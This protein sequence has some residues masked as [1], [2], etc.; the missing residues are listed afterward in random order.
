MGKF[1]TLAKNTAASP[2]IKNYEGAKAYKPSARLDLYLA[3]ATT[4]LDNSFYESKDVR[5]ERIKEL[6]KQ[7]GPVFTVQL[8]AYCRD[9]L[10]MR[11][12]SVALL[13]E[14]AMLKDANAWKRAEKTLR[15]YVPRIL[16]RADELAEFISY[17]KLYNGSVK[18]IPKPIE[19]GMSDALNR[20]SEYQL[21]KYRGDS[22]AV[23][24][25]DV[26]RII[27]PK[28]NTSEKAAL[29]KRALENELATPETWEVEI[30]TKGSTDE[31]WNEI[32]PKMGIMALLRNLRNFE[33]KGAEKALQHAISVLTNK[34][35][36]VNSKQL[37]FRWFS[38][39][40]QVTRT[41]TQNA[42]CDAMD[43]SVENV[44]GIS[45]V[46]A[47]FC[48][49]SGSMAAPVSGKSKVSRNDAA[50]ILS[51][52]AFKKGN[53][54]VLAGVFGDYFQT[55]KLNQRDT[56]LTNAQKLKATQVGCSTNGYLSIQ[57]LRENGIVVDKL[58][59]FTDEELYSTTPSYG[60]GALGRSVNQNTVQTE[61]R[62][63]QKI[64]PN[65]KLYVI[66]LAGYGQ[67]MFPESDHSVVTIGGFS[68][69]IFKTL[70]LV[71][72]GESAIAEI[73]KL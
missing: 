25:R 42:L 46:I 54:K 36:V 64:A 45:G 32:A 22:K 63:Y 61:W 34:E 1:N 69:N 10:H 73:E 37:P 27:H 35:A 21:A 23:K 70:A 51:A 26:I 44:E 33:Q 68:E 18:G 66:D 43:L 52:I 16:Q 17:W 59:M 40:N 67:L 31:N 30:S 4:F 49:N 47:V 57:A 7:V 20:F 60:W 5:I 13:A 50:T 56:I 48:D 11:S 71:E 55:V 39:M 15:S 14:A 29:W 65:A 28:P 19:R 3:C 24:L 6:V 62:L 41:E 2:V 12:V 8:A 53:S 9:E 58:Y 38:A 72:N